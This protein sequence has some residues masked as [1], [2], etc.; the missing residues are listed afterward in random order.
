MPKFD[1]EAIRDALSI[2]EYAKYRGVE[3][4]RSGDELRGSCPICAGQTRAPFCVREPTFICHQCLAQGDIFALCQEVEQVPFTEAAKRLA[5]LAGMDEEMSTEDRPTPPRPVKP[6]VSPPASRDANDHDRNSRAQAEERAAALWKSMDT[7]DSQGLAYLERRGVASLAAEV[8]YHHERVCIPLRDAHGTIVNVVR[9]RIHPG[10]PKVAGLKGCGTRGTFGDV[11]KFDHTEGAIVIVEGVFDWLSARAL[12][13]Q[14]L[15]LG[16]HGAGRIADVVTLIADRCQE[17]GII[18]VPH[19]DKNGVGE[20]QTAKAIAAAQTAGVPSDCIYV[21]DVGDGCCDLNDYLIT[22]ATSG[23][24]GDPFAQLPSLEDK[25]NYRVFRFHDV[26]AAERFAH[27]HRDNL[28]YVADMGRWLRWSGKSWE[29]AHKETDLVRAA[30]KVAQHVERQAALTEASEPEVAEELKEHAYKLQTTPR[31]EAMIKLACAAPNLST[32]LS[33]LDRNPFLLAVQ[34]GTID[35]RTGELKPHRREDLLTC[36]SP[37]AYDPDAQCPRWLRFIKEVFEPNPDAAIFVQRYAGYSLT[38][39][40][41]AQCLL[42]AHGGGGNGKGVLFHLIE[43]VFG[44]DLVQTAPFDAFVERRLGESPS[45]A[46]A[47]FRGRRALLVPEGKKGDRLN[48]SLIK[49]IT[50]GDAI[51]AR[52]LYGQYFEYRPTYKIWMSSNYKPQ[53][54]GTDEGIW[55]RLKLVPFEV[56][57]SARRDDHLEKHLAQELPGILAWAVRGC[58]DWVNDGG[59]IK[60][61]GDAPSV[62]EAT[63]EYRSESDTIGG[64]LE[65]CCVTTVA[66]ARISTKELYRVYREWAQSEGCNPTNNRNF[67][68]EL[69]RRSFIRRKSNGTPYYYGVGLLADHPEE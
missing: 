13:P 19:K 57:F 21:F 35:L 16:A 54:H 15:I 33:Q 47:D 3:L 22:R 23:G 24:T 18:F 49:Q 11:R 68:R 66:E 17:R 34:N 42:F 4:R 27:V 55:R 60:G 10:E 2:A 69:A 63:E 7:S 56:D 5:E 6:A 12:A 61:L 32:S 40:T 44:S 8:R 37:V 64:F 41:S 67:G 36:R 53:V 1:T 20:K 52:F 25:K 59:G 14:R 39:D 26:G 51:K 46:L 31:I 58:L 30:I 50:G 48:E 29:Y 43:Q 28:R 62:S 38:A 45:H 65:E 9:R